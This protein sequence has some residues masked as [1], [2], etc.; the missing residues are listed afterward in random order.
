M[1]LP[2]VILPVKRGSAE[3][4]CSL[5]CMFGLILYCIQLYVRI[6][7]VFVALYIVFWM[8]ACVIEPRDLCTTPLDFDCYIESAGAVRKNRH[9]WRRGQ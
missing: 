3:L 6:L 5:Y 8:P 4:S 9:N 2:V 1:V 7:S